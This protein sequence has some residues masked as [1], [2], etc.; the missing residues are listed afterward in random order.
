MVVLVLWCVCVVAALGV[1][2]LSVFMWCVVR[3]CVCVC[4]DS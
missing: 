2:V 3:W 4:V 1:W